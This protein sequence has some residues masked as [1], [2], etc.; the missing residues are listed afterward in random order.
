MADRGRYFMDACVPIY[1]AGGEHPYKESCARI[2]MGIARREIE[3]ATDTEVIQEVAYRFHAIGRR[4]EGLEVAEGVLSL[5]EEVLPVTRRDA[6]RFLELQ[7]SYPFLSTRDAVHVAV[8]MGAGLGLI[9]SA[10]R[11]FDGVPEV[12][13]V[14]PL[15][16]HLD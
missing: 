1:A 12:H 7:R 16:L 3:A 5:M 14:D 6:T 15:D 4:A 9:I 2:I 8:M 13:R 10:D 11:H